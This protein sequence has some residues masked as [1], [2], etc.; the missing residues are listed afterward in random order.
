MDARGSLR[1]LGGIGE[2]ARAVFL[3][4]L[5][6]LRRAVPDVHLLSAPE[7]RADESRSEEPGTEER[8]GHHLPPAR[9][10]YERGMM[11]SDASTGWRSRRVTVILFLPSRS[12]IRK[13]K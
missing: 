10:L 6:L 8:D 11:K 5:R 4:R 1:C 13:G 12:A 3:E 2:R 9:F 7:E